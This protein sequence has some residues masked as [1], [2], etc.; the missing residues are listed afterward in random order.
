MG[1]TTEKK[2]KKE[3][4]TGAHQVPEHLKVSKKVPTGKPSGRPSKKND[5]RGNHLRKNPIPEH[6]LPP[7]KVY[8]PTGKPRGRPKETEVEEPEE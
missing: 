2:E 5:P 4:E 8:V 7:K 3:E 1:R 6:L